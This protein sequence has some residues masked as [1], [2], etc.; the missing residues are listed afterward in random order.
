MVKHDRREEVRRL[1]VRRSAE[2]LTYRE[3]SRES[4]IP[5]GT[6][7]WWSSRLR[8]KGAGEAGSFVELT[9][10]ISREPEHEGSIH[11]GSGLEVVLPGGRRLVVRPG[12]DESELMRL[13]RTLESS[14]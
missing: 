5:A 8:A 12:F 6:L 2:G 9:A 10:P 11:V 14:C 13:V 1:L 7:A 4:G 3:L